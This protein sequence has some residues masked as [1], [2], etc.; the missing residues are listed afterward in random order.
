MWYEKTF[1]IFVDSCIRKTQKGVC[2]VFPFTYKGKK[3]FNC[4]TKS[5]NREWCA[6]TKNYDKDGAWGNC[7]GKNSILQLELN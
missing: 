1:L 2:C 4:T 5:H 6:T 7:V 3:Y